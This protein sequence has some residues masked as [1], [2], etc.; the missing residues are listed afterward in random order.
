MHPAGGDGTPATGT[1]TRTP[2]APVTDG[3][4]NNPDLLLPFGVK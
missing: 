3:M 2:A 4:R 1:T